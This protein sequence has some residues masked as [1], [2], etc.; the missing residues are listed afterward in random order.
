M[1]AILPPV[2][3]RERPQELRAVLLEQAPRRHVQEREPGRMAGGDDHV[4]SGFG[5]FGQPVAGLFA[6]SQDAIRVDGRGPL[7]EER[8]G[9]ESGRGG[10]H[11]EHF[12]G[13]ELVQA[14]QAELE[15]GIAR[16]QPVDLPADVPAV[17]GGNG[18]GHLAGQEG[19]GQLLARVLGASPRI[20]PLGRV[21]HLV[22]GWLV[23]SSPHPHD[24][25]KMSATNDR[26]VSAHVR[27]TF[28][29]VRSMCFPMSTA[30][31]LSHIV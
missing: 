17:V 8:V 19:V 23:H 28:V 22:P 12:V 13:A 14:G 4:I 21:E 24:S 10:H 16:H 7:V 5:G 2:E 27:P 11:G 20:G 31:T 18:P 9:V 29:L 3:A 6:R 25:R 26:E 1:A 15:V 30:H